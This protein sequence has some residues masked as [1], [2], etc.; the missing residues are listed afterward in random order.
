MGFGGALVLVDP[1]MGRELREEELIDAAT[2]EPTKRV[3]VEDVADETET[4]WRHAAPPDPAPLPSWRE[5]LGT[6][7]APRETPRAEPEVSGASADEPDHNDIAMV[8]LALL[9]GW[10]FAKRS[11]RRR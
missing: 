11:R 3:T 8:G 7:A 6:K 5:L 9:V 2:S 10:S 4:L 1:V